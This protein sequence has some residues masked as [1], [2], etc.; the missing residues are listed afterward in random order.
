MWLLFELGLF[1]SRVLVL[2]DDT[3]EEPDAVGVVKEE[4]ENQTPS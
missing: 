2:R 4:N 1:F 3:G